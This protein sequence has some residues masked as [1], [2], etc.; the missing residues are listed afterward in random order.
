MSKYITFPAVDSEYNFPPEILNKLYSFPT[1]VLQN[2]AN[3]NEIEGVFA[4]KNDMFMDVRSHGALIDGTSD[5]SA[6]IMSAFTSGLPV[7]FPPGLYRTSTVL[8][9]PPNSSMILSPGAVFSPLTDMDTYVWYFSNGIHIVGELRVDI[10]A[11]MVKNRGVRIVGWITAERIT[12][13]ASNPGQASHSSNAVGI[14]FDKASGSVQNISILN[15]D[16]ATTIRDCIHLNISNLDINM[17]KR[18]VYI[19]DSKHI[20]LHGHIYGRSPN[21]GLLP[22]HNGIIIEA[23]SD[24]AVNYINL[25]RVIVEDSGEHGIRLGGAFIIANVEHNACVVSNVDGSGFKSLGGFVSSNIN[26]Q[27]INYTDCIAEDCG[28]SDGNCCGFQI[29]LTRNS[30]LT[31]PIV[32]TKNKTYS[33][34]TGIRLNGC[35]N[36]IVTNPIILN[37]KRAGYAVEPQLGNNEAIRLVGGIIRISDGWGINIDYEGITN[38][39][40]DI[41]GRV[42]IEA[43]GTSK[44]INVSNNGGLGVTVGNAFMSFTTNSIVGNIVE[45]TAPGQNYAGYVFD[46]VAPYS[47]I[48]AKNSSTWQDPVGGKMYLRKGGTWVE[49]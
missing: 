37:T 33:A 31:S 23:Y 20:R 41:L 45:T 5:D 1:H 2:I 3:S 24:Y 49:Q 18:G 13:N 32:R 21:A 29:Q 11:E 22:G 30:Q 26:H 10:P 6:A 42:S 17:Y 48:G 14:F 4:K 16:F 46:V 28:I 34:D 44:C 47:N 27:N 19:R 36:V 12:I 15:Y 39:R 7:F 43:S 35:S 8:T 25:D 9:V 38:R 40:V